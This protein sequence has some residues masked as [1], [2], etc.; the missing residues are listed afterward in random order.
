MPSLSAVWPKQ[1]GSSGWI[2]ILL[3]LNF[4][5]HSLLLVGNAIRVFF[6]SVMFLSGSVMHKNII[7]SGS[8]SSQ[9]LF[10]E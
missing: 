1:F 3:W 10:C 5:I 2:C 4:R 6:F 8:G 9:S 7:R